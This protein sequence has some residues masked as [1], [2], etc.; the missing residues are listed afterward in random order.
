MS[1]RI[2]IKSGICLFCVATIII[3]PA[4][5][6]CPAM[7]LLGSPSA[8]M[9]QG[10][11]SVGADLAYSVDDLELS[12]GTWRDYI[13]GVFDGDGKTSDLTIKDFKTNSGY[14]N[15]SYGVTDFFEV[16]ARM[17]GSKAR[18]GDSIWRNSEKFHSE[19][20][21]AFGIGCKVTF[22]DLNNSEYSYFKLGAIFQADTAEYN[23][24]LYADNWAKMGWTPDYVEVRMTQLKIAFGADC[25]L[26]EGF[27]V[28]GGPFLHFI[29]G[30][31]YDDTYMVDGG[32]SLL[33]T[34]YKWDIK[35]DSAFGGY[36]GLRG[37]LAGIYS[38][39]FEFQHTASADVIGI[40]LGCQF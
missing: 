11:L 26:A 15:L 37:E 16:F 22:L 12:N 25:T 23:G 9:K 4:G 18:F 17:G 38:L 39:T 5:Q 36:V 34:E 3:S 7:E 35:E 19:A 32:G 10:W 27:S 31:F 13:D 2:S 40:S 8:G 1:Q 6:F 21:P 30:E 28:Y 24:Q 33:N 14:A 20:E 29:S